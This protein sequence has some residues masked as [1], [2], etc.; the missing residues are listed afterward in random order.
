MTAIFNHILQKQMQK[1]R[2][3]NQPLF[4]IILTNL[5]AIVDFKVSVV[6]LEPV[7][8]ISIDKD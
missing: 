6:L 7:F 4:S 5:S 3:W 8:I 1:K 2:D